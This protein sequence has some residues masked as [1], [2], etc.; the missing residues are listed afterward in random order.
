VE[1]V[2]G[3]ATMVRTTVVKTRRRYRD[4]NLKQLADITLHWE[5]PKLADIYHSGTPDLADDVDECAIEIASLKALAMHHTLKHNDGKRCHVPRGAF[6][7]ANKVC[8]KYNLHRSEI[9]IETV[10][11]RNKV[12]RKLKVETKLGESLK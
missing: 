1:K 12:G 3:K 9:Q 7:R 11:S 10:F 5:E 4:S 6:E 8:A 2:G